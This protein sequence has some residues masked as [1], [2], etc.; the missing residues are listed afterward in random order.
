MAGILTKG[1]KKK[2]FRIKGLPLALVPIIITGI[3]I[4]I[5]GLIPKVG[6]WYS[7]DQSFRLQTNAFLRGEL[8]L[9]PVPYGHRF[10]WAWGNGIHQ[11]W[12]L[13]VPIIRLPFEII[14]KTFGSLGFPDRIVFAI[15][16][17]LVAAIFWKS[18]DSFIIHNLD[19]RERL[20]KRVRNIPVLF[21]G[22]L[23]PAFITMIRAKFGPYEEVI[24][25]GY[26][27]SLMLFALILL[28]L[29]NRKS[30]LFFL[31][32]FLA[33]FSPSIRPTL[34]SYGIV[35]FLVI[36]F[37]GKGIKSRW[38]G[39][40]LFSAGIMF[41]LVTNY[42]R[43][44]SP[45]E[46]GQ[47]LLL[48]GVLVI[49]YVQRFGNPVALMPFLDAVRELFSDLFFTDINTPIFLLDEKVLQGPDLPRLREF[50]F[51]PYDFL[52]P[53]LLFLSWLTIAL[54]RCNKS[55]INPSL[56]E[57]A[58]QMGGLWSFCSFIML[59]YFY[60]RFPV[61]T[62]RYFVDF[63]AS[64]VIG[65]VAL[66]L[67]I[68]NLIQDKFSR[69]ATMLN[70]ILCIA[71]LGW[72]LYRLTHAEIN[73]HYGHRSEIKNLV[74]KTAEV[75]QEE[76]ARMRRTTGPL[77]PVEY[78]CRDQETSYGIPSNN[79]GWDI[80]ASCMVQLTT[81]HFL[82][83]PEC[84]DI[85][86]EPVGGIPDWMA[87]I[88]SDEGEEIEVRKGLS[89]MHRISDVKSGFGKIITFCADRKDNIKKDKG[90]QIELISIKWS[91]LQKH[92]NLSTPPLRL[93]SLSKV[94]KPIGHQPY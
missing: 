26:L 82:D 56:G 3:M 4:Y 52:T 18:L 21:W 79:L 36:F 93:I 37:L 65:I 47:K 33:G 58:I 69:N 5:T 42:L 74:A 80:T 88:Y 30:Y 7:F 81:T 44:N 77:L 14:S 91:D 6:D 70:L 24:A 32:C 53:L 27:W 12:G 64:I 23:N 9:N 17:F 49:D 8:A 94:D 89:T 76:L 38:L 92:P 54:R 45:F 48:S 40:L 13:G 86:I 20:K 2:L 66:Y 28:F 31:V 15:F 90:R 1:S 73:F 67:Y 55:N 22:L 63:G 60:S 34:L 35:T 43:F 39:L 11:I 57:K 50:Y 85:H 68:G 25:Y 72:G 62:S 84:L 75:A 83:A 16:Y 71:F 78:K 19:A 41:L 61:L 29:N 51:R 87:K 59:F 10:D 46:F